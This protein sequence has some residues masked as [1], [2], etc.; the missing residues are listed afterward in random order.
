VNNVQPDPLTDRKAAE[1][2]LREIGY[3]F[4]SFRL[5]V[6]RQYQDHLVETTRV[7]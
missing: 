4:P 6:L 2:A 5:A 3:P 1:Q 7:A